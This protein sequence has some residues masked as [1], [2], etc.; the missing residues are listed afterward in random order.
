MLQWA[1]YAK[2]YQEN[3]D[4]PLVLVKEFVT[5]NMGSWTTTLNGTEVEAVT[6][7][8]RGLVPVKQA[9]TI[10]DIAFS[11]GTDNT[12]DLT[13]QGNTLSIRT[14]S[15]LGKLNDS[16]YKLTTAI[17]NKD[18]INYIAI[19]DLEYLLNLQPVIDEILEETSEEIIEETEESEVLEDHTSSE[20]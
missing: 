17:Y 14:N 1:E 3:K 12:F 18:N 20:Y 16:E 15:N 13:Y 4:V 2:A 9:C 19:K 5:K 10:Y 11:Y 6:L 8:G 7:Y